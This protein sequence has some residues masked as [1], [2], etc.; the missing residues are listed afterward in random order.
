[1]RS[2][3]Q[4]AHQDRGQIALDRTGGA[5]RLPRLRGAR[6]AITTTVFVAGVW[7][8]AALLPGPAAA[9][10]PA[11]SPIL[12]IFSVGGVLT[13]DGTL[14][15]YSPSRKWQTIDEAFRDQG[16]ETHILP[17]PVPAKS[18]EE[19]VTFGFL[20]T[21]GGDVWLYDLEKDEWNHLEPPR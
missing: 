4:F 19:M 14:W 5:G 13:A 3:G 1:M 6:A 18:I 16:K 2:P 20:R 7:L 9:Q 11:P 8:A 12:R 17:L 10:D 21:T 15:Q